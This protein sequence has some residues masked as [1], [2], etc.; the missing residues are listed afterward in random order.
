MDRISEEH[1]TSGPEIAPVEIEAMRAEIRALDQRLQAFE[2]EDAAVSAPQEREEALLE[3]TRLRLERLKLLMGLY[4]LQ[5]R[6]QVGIAVA[7]I[8]HEVQNF[9]MVILGHA[10]Y[11]ER[12]PQKAVS[13]LQ[14]V[15]KVSLETRDSLQSLLGFL[16]EREVRLG[17][18]DLLHIAGEAVALARRA[19]PE[20][21]GEIVVEESGPLTLRTDRVLLQQALLNLLLN[22]IQAIGGGRGTIR[23][24]AGAGDGQIW[25]RIH[26]DGPGIPEEMRGRIYEPFERR[27]GGEERAGLGLFVTRQIVEGLGGSIDLEDTEKGASFRIL[28]P[29]TPATAEGGE[30][31]GT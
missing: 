23:V 4:Q 29:E 31:R 17:E 22:G 20:W 28:L 9:L 6:A 16:M 10:W 19:D 3:A 26:D 1:G 7:G 13:E 8:V 5:R 2:G 18:H 11:G 12:V 21:L 25:A 24:S 14:A 27:E 30:E 15:Q